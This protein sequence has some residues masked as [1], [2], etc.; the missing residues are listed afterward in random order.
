MK[1]GTLMMTITYKSNVEY[2]I[3]GTRIGL[4]EE[5]VTLIH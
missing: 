4:P 5:G 2:R 3:N 1:R